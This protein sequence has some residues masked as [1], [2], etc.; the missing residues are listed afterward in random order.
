MYFWYTIVLLRYKT[1]GGFTKSTRCCTFCVR[2]LQE[3]FV[4]LQQN[5]DS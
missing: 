2:M 3:F 5:R 1:N 4:T